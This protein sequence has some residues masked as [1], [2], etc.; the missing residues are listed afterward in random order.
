[1]FDMPISS[2]KLS[3]CGSEALGS[4]LAYLNSMA[5][6]TTGLVACSGQTSPVAQLTSTQLNQRVGLAA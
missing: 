6:S 4:D 2:S 1:M 5:S 3:D